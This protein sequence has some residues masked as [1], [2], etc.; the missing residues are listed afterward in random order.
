MAQIR[1]QWNMALGTAVLFLI[2]LAINE[3]VF[4]HSEFI[5]GVNWIYLPAGVRLLCT[6]LFGVSGAI[7]LLIASWA[8]CFLY[9]FPDD[10]IR[11]TIGGILSATAPYI[12]YLFAQHSLDLKKNLSNLT[13]KRLLLC[14]VIYALSNSTLHHAWFALDGWKSSLI[15]SFGVMLLG[16][17]IGSVVVLYTMKIAL[18]IISKRSIPRGGI[19]DGS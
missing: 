17:L 4:S 15:N 2:V 1:F 14:A 16:D 12:A 3:W 6:L 18:A 13:S 19:Q 10:F 7:G 8:A 9:L 11:S 5:R